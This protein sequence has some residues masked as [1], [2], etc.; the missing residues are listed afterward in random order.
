M[1][2]LLRFGFLE[3]NLNCIYLDVFENN[4][5]AISCYE[6]CGFKREGALRERVY[7]NGKYLN[8]FKMSILKREFLEKVK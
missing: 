5:R 3:M 8:E 7:K 1:N 2:T 6:K 4:P